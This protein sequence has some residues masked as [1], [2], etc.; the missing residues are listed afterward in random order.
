MVFPDTITEQLRSGRGETDGILELWNGVPYLTPLWSRRPTVTF[1]HHVHR[2]IWNL[3]LSGKLAQFGRLLEGRLAPP[4]YRWS[5]IL[6]PSQASKDEIIDYLGLP[7]ENI[8]VVEPGVDSMFTQGVG[9]S[10]S[11]TIVAVGRLVP[12][13][14]FETLVSIMPEVSRRVPGARLVIVGDGYNRAAIEAAVLSHGASHLVEMRGRVTNEELIAAYREAWVLA[15]ASIAEGWGMTITEAGACGTPAVVSRVGG[16]VDAVDHDVSGLLAGTTEELTES[17]VRV[18][19][20]ADLR[21][22]LTDGAVAAAADH[23]WEATA[24]AVI[25]ELTR[26]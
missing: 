19:C 25:E 20:D 10:P 22:R 8:R 9:R 15:S 12:Y 1:I 17:L 3:T 21:R 5:R 2:E 11:P 7:S 24:T 18:L 23:S 4:L 6:T 14:R 26:V 13:K 16:H